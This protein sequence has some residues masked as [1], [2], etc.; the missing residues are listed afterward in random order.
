MLLLFPAVLYFVVFDY[1]LLLLTRR[2][3]ERK[4]YS[5]DDL[6]GWI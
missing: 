1:S 3:A 2:C 4:C 6:V 5:S